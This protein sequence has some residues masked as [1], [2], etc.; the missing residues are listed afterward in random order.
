MPGASADDLIGHRYATIV[1][2]DPVHPAAVRQ[3]YEALELDDVDGQPRPEQVV[4]LSTYLTFA[5]P[6]YREPHELL[7]DARLPPLPYH[8]V[9]SRFGARAMATVVDVTGGRPMR[10]GDRITSWW[11]V[12]GVDRRPTRL[13]PGIFVDFEAEFVNQHAQRVALE[14]TRILVFQPGAQP[15][16]V[17]PSSS[18]AGPPGPVAGGGPPFVRS[19]PRVG[20][21]LAALRLG[22]SLQRLVMIAGANRDF[23]PVHH[24]PLAAKEIGASAPIVNSMFL[25]TLAERMA[26]EAGGWNTE[27]LRLGPLRMLRPTPAGTT[28]VC[29][30]EVLEVTA[31]ED[32]IRVRAEMWVVVEPGG[33][34]ARCGLE[35]VVGRSA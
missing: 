8:L 7:V 11:T 9:T 16:S 10:F 27:I 31:H 18:A 26:Y 17:L 13:G 6:A 23:A 32:G 25:L 1:G 12:R 20:Q 34:T 24:D 28:L 14:R 5:M 21:W 2:A 4:P 15:A 35:F 29:R 30:A 19:A 33:T 3:L 22:M